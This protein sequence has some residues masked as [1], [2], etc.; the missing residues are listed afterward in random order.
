MLER[1]RATQQFPIFSKLFVESKV[2]GLGLSSIAISKFT[3][4]TPNEDCELNNFY[5]ERNSKNNKT[6]NLVGLFEGPRIIGFGDYE[7]K[8]GSGSVK[9]NASKIL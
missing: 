1:L 8:N 7:F 5:I 3:F 4:K 6:F 9:L 2:L